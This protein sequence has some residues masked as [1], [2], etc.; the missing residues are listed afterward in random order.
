MPAEELIEWRF[1]D[2]GG[3]R[4]ALDVYTPRR[5][6]TPEARE[7]HFREWLRETPAH[8]L[9]FV[10]VADSSPWYNSRFEIY[11]ELTVF[12]ERQPDFVRNSSTRRPM[13][14]TMMDGW[15]P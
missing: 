4:T 13:H 5:R 3:E 12:V 2:A 14:T 15:T 1:V 11:R 10:D 6:P 7:A 8:T 9:V